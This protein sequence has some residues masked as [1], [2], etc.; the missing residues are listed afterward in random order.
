MNKES[1]I[2]YIK[3][4]ISREFKSIEVDLKEMKEITPVVTMLFAHPDGTFVD[5]D[6]PDVHVFFRSDKAKDGLV[7]YVHH[8]HALAEEMGLSHEGEIAAIIIVADVFWVRKQK[9]EYEKMSND[10]RIPPS[11]DPERME[12]IMF[13]VYMKD[14]SFTHVFPYER[15][16]GIIIEEP[17]ILDGD[18]GGRFDKIFP[19]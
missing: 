13:T 12:A 19:G 15:K 17:H 8:C 9:D 14:Y 5:I 2:K 10:E 3:E 16:D 6:V 18:V 4:Y 11:Q 1:T 7:T